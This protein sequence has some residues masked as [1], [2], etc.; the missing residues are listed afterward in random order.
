MRI[1]TVASIVLAGFLQ[2]W[3]DVTPSKQTP[4]KFL[5][6]RPS[7]IS[8]WKDR[9][10]ALHRKVTNCR[11]TFRSVCIGNS[12]AFEDILFVETVANEPVVSGEGMKSKVLIEARRCSYESNCNNVVWSINDDSDACDYVDLGDNNEFYKT[13]KYGCCGGENINRFYDTSSGKYLMTCSEDGIAVSGT[14]K[15]SRVAVTYLSANGYQFSR[16]FNQNK[17]EMGLISLYARD[18]LLDQVLV[19]SNDLD[20]WTPRVA[21]LTDKVKLI[22]KD[23]Q[24]VIIPILQGQLDVAHVQSN[25][26][27]KVVPLNSEK[28]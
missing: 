23:A 21:L 4:P 15:E 18:T 16:R 5:L 24:Q 2:L 7:S 6:Q 3:A 11:M 28:K 25:V 12:S 8:V 17:G 9:T 27:V 26:A 10:G 20:P 14:H 13:T 19:I 1:V 22:Y